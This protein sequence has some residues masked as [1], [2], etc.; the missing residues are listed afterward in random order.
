MKTIVFE[1]SGKGNFPLDMLRYDQCWPR[2]PEDVSRILDQVCNGTKK[3]SINLTS[4]SQPTVDRW[5]SFC[6]SCET[7]KY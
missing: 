5:K 3:V 4:Y 2:S 7:R 1:V 6:W